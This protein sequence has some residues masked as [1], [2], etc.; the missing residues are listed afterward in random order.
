[1][2]SRG[3]RLFALLL[4]SVT[5][6]SA[7]A[8]QDIAQDF[9]GYIPPEAEAPEALLSL[10]V[11]S[12]EV[13]LYVEGTWLVGL[14]AGVGVRWVPGQGPAITTG[15]STRANGV[16]LRQEPSLELSVLL[17]D[18]F[19]LETAIRQSDTQLSVF[20]PSQ[21]S[22]LRMGYR[23]RGDELLRSVILGT[24]GVEMGAYP[25]VQVPAMGRSSLGAGAVI[26]G[27]RARQEILLR[28]DRLPG[29]SVRYVGMNRVT[30][31]RVSPSAYLRGQVFL[32]PDRDVVGLVVL[33][34]DPRGTVTDAAGRHY[35]EPAVSEVRV[36]ASEG[37]VVFTAPVAGSVVVWYED[38][39]GNDVGSPLLGRGFLP[40]QTLGSDKLPTVD[41]DGVPLD[42]Q[43]G[44]PTYL[45]E[46]LDDRQVVID[47]RTYLRIGRPGEFSP[48]EAAQ[49]YATTLDGGAG[50]RVEL[51]VV[52]RGTDLAAGNAGGGLVFVPSA[53]LSTF[54]VSRGSDPRDSIRDR[55]PFEDAG[56]LLYGPSSPP[57]E[58]YLDYVIRVRAYQ[59]VDEL[60]VP[61]PVVSGSVRVVRG[62]VDDPAFTVD[63]ATGRVDLGT[64]VSP[65]EEIEIY[66]RSAEGAAGTDLV[67]AWGNRI[68]LGEGAVLEL[69]G[70]LVW[71]LSAG[72]FTTEA[73]EALG[74]VVASASLTGAYTTPKD[75]ESAASPVLDLD[76]RVAA[77]VSLSQPDTTGTRRLFGMEGER[78]GVELTEDYARPSALP[79]GIGALDA[80]GRGRMIYRDYRRYALLGGTTLR[81][82]EDTG[83]VE[84]PYVDGEITGPY[85][86]G[87]SY[88]AVDSGSSLAVQFEMDDAHEWA[89]MQIPLSDGAGI[90]NLSG[91]ESIL[92]SYLAEV[93]E[94]SYTVWLQAGALGEDLDGDGR[95]DAEEPGLDT[96]FW[97]D[98][99]GNGVSLRV[100]AGPRG[101]G[102]GIQDT[103]DLDGNGYLDSEEPAVT[104][105][106][107]TVTAGAGEAWVV[108]RRSLSSEERRLLS[109]SRGV[110]LVAVRDGSG[111]VRGRILVDRVELS[112]SVFW[113]AAEGDWDTLAVR[114]V[115]ETDLGSAE[116]AP[117][118]L[119]TVYPEVEDRYHAGGGIQKVLE[120]VW[121]G[122][123]PAGL[124]LRG[125]VDEGTG[126][127]PY[128]EL[129][130][131]LRAPELGA[132]AEVRMDLVDGA[133]EGI[134]TTIPLSP[135]DDWR[136]LVVDTT[137]STVTLA[138]QIV[139]DTVVAADPGNPDLVELRLEI[140]GADSGRVYLDEVRLSTPDAGVGVA[141]EAAIRLRLSGPLV[142]AGDTVLVSTLS[143]GLRVAASSADFAPLFGQPSRQPGL[144]ADADLGVETIAGRLTVRGAGESTAAGLDLSGGHELDLLY[145]R[146]GPVQI[147][148]RDVFATGGA[149]TDLSHRSD[150]GL[151]VGWL[152]A[153]ALSGSDVAGAV[154]SQNWSVDLAIRPPSAPAVTLG[155]VASKRA[156]GYAPAG[157]WYLPWWAEGY[158]LLVPWTA[159]VDAARSATL[160]AAA[161]LPPA[162]VG[163]DL[164]ARTGFDTTALAGT[165]RSQKTTL[166]YGVTVPVA[167]RPGGG[168]EVTVSAGYRT[169][170]QLSATREEGRTDLVEDAQALGDVLARHLWL[171]GGGPLADVLS[172]AALVRNVGR[173]ESTNDYPLTD[174]LWQ[175]EITL[176][177]AR[178][179]GS[180]LV[181]LVLPVYLDVTLGRRA[182]LT[183]DL[184]GADT[185]LRASTRM[186]ALNLFGRSGSLR[187]FDFYDTD[188]LSATATVALTA[189][190]APTATTVQ[191]VSVAVSQLVGLAKGETRVELENKLRVSVA[192]QTRVVDEVEARLSWTHRVGMAVPVIL[193]NLGL[194]GR[195]AEATGRLVHV[196]RAALGLDGEDAAGLGSLSIT[197]RH[198]TRVEYPELG[199]VAARAGL[200]LEGRREGAATAWTLTVGVEAALEVVLRF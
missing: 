24:N 13:D 102:N 142:A 4:L 20:L 9:A 99:A 46:N 14:E 154:L 113:A 38:A 177:L 128:R 190:L 121:S 167:F 43:W 176:G 42:F 31:S 165:R 132:P 112:G 33:I 186:T 25:F 62:G 15:A 56:G 145:P 116:S 137:A 184:T 88:T 85:E 83:Y 135:F 141:G 50:A 158:T 58:G 125:F 169:L 29:S 191:D 73:G 91:A 150:M 39:A 19:F 143:A 81:S 97:F 180:R 47:G 89:G 3:P 124:T 18:M 149:A 182:V 155:L 178:G 118:T 198:E 187:V 147:R 174:A 12:A 185:L 10:D 93:S 164:L 30:E 90:A 28:V 171:L 101:Q 1:M 16:S 53:D 173:L 181:D 189:P 57:P 34:E 103:E 131:Y 5:L 98:D 44:A 48:F 22:Y 76:Y 199:H 26:E 77:A 54:T 172:P 105:E 156:T 71:N 55:Y 157:A 52:G 7:L 175:P 95:L 36:S 123:D 196:E 49:T 94:G 161:R 67:A 133:G 114:E 84:H 119:E 17:M 35:R 122:L 21:I 59:P 146:S 126:G 78:R 61:T 130:L 144:R 6:R 110:R 151:T 82:Y 8:A 75:P 193:T 66:Y 139:A 160:Q 60:S 64:P 140:V 11:G 96:G 107:A 87:G 2:P 32:L 115:K 159:G 120:L 195:R 163:F 197:L 152:T 148:Y 162:P 106:L 166:S 86:V 23:A 63:Y 109:R 170:V 80:A 45:D 51:D 70:G 200:A 40:A 74:G 153:G 65:G 188:E 129:T 69:A 127:I 138:G 41:P 108:E 27:P 136:E 79:V 72:A 192:A 100:G 92:I 37:W 68:G 117:Q 179:E 194:E 168:P 134:H 104:I 111:P 183:G